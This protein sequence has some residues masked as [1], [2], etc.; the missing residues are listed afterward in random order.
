MTPNKLRF[1]PGNSV[2]VAD[3]RLGLFRLEG[4]EQAF[5]GADDRAAGDQDRRHGSQVDGNGYANNVAERHCFHEQGS[6]CLTR[7]GAPIQ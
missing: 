3:G 7:A 5:D 4:P 1:D 6:I 2:V